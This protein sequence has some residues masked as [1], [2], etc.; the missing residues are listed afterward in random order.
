[1]VEDHYAA[2]QAWTEWARNRGRES[3]DR[4]ADRRAGV[5]ASSAALSEECDRRDRDRADMPL[6]QLA[7]HPASRSTRHAP[8]GQL[9]TR[10]RQSK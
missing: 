10:L 4:V 5:D 7:G 1:M 6:R 3:P 8:Y 9:F 2:L